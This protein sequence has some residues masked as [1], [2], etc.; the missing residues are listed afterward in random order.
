M[1]VRIP[2]TRAVVVAG[3]IWALAACGSVSGDSAGERVA[4]A[5]STDTS[6]P[7]AVAGDP[8]LASYRIAADLPPCPTGTPGSPV[9]EPQGQVGGGLPDLTLECLDEGPAVTLSDLRG[10]PILLNVWASWCPPC[11]AEMPLLAEAAR[12]HADELIV[13]GVDVEDAPGPALSLAAEL[14]LNF[15][16]VVDERGQ[17][18]A[19]LLV[20]GPPV[21]FFVTADGVIAGRHDGRIPDQETLEALLAEYLGIGA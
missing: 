5:S 16:S 2:L 19:A 21:T 18:R 1:R 20:P 14:D 15:P 7:V 8:G 13:L 6:S 10:T 4:G 9:I 17:A 11:I 3:A 12:V